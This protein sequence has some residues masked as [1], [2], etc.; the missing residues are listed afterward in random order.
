MRSSGTLSLLLAAASVSA[1]SIVTTSVAPTSTVTPSGP[2]TGE[3]G[4]AAVVNDN[5][6]GVVYKAVLPKEAFFK[7]AFPEGGNI[8]GEVTAEAHKD[9]KGVK[10][11]I[12]LSNLPKIGAALPYHLH[13][14]PVPSNGNCTATLAHLDPYIRGEATPCDKAAP[15][16]CQVGDLSGKHGAIPADVGTWETSYVDPYAS[17]VEGIGAF[18]GNRSIV[19]HYP[20]KTRITCASFAK[21]EGGVKLPSGG[22]TTLPTVSTFSSATSLPTGIISNQTTTQSPS[23]TTSRPVTPPTSTNV[24]VG[25]ASGL[26]VGAAGAAVFGA[27]L[28]WLL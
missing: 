27:A 9:G 28:A 8:E 12:K 6:A 4:D 24:V 19:F 10:F 7:P 2:S 20:N 17:T 11:T 23:S 1:Q 14:D 15:A 21:V 16:T 18:F 5:P 13:V 3:L 25:A 22:I 26:R